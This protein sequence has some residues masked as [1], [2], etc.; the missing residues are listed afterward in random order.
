MLSKLKNNYYKCSLIQFN[1]SNKPPWTSSTL[2][3][4]RKVQEILS[5]R[6]KNILLFNINDLDEEDKC[7]E[8]SVKH[9]NGLPRKMLE[10][11]SL[12][13][14][15]KWL[16]LA[17]SAMLKLIQWS[18]IKVWS[19]WSGRSFPAFNDFVILCPDSLDEFYR[20]AKNKSVEIQE[21]KSICSDCKYQTST[22][23][24]VFW[25]FQCLMHSFLWAVQR[26]IITLHYQWGS[27]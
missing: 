12:E 17:L 26:N 25:I 9:C 16:D 19:W 18:S 22:S 4:E 7:T 24:I 13:V 6:N 14:L 1:L 8:R 5:I 27:S 2:C 20:S 21:R 3:F 10:L 23:G 15:K 11:P